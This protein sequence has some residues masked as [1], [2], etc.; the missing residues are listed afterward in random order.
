LVVLLLALG[1]G[2]RQFVLIPAMRAPLLAQ[3]KDPDSAQFRGDWYVGPWSVSQGLYCGQVNGRNEM[4]GYEGYRP[5]SAVGGVTA[6]VGKPGNP[7]HEVC[8]MSKYPTP[9]WWLRW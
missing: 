4:G 3:M 1:A 7:P 9:F 6:V 8:D 2:Y 5:F